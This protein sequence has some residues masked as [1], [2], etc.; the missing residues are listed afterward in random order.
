MKF[1]ATI[2]ATAALSVGLMAADKETTLTGK[3]ECAKCSLGKTKSCQMAI[4]VKQDG[5]DK[6]YMLENNDITK[7]FHK[8]ICQEDKD[9]KIT[10]TLKD[11]D[12][13]QVFVAKKVELAKK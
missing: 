1:L 8:N 5:K 6:T 4:T 13:K 9:V 10:G 2:I 12:G 7:A 11:V 3:G